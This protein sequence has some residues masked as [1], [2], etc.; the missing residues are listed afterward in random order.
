MLAN[1]NKKK[2]TVTVAI[3]YPY[4]KCGRLYHDYASKRQK[5]ARTHVYINKK[6]ENVPRKN[7]KNFNK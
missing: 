6:N 3:M 5:F 4:A 7:S 2:F 1:P